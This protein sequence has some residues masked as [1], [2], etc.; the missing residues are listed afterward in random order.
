[1][2]TSTKKR[3]IVMVAMGGHAFMKEGQK[4]NNGENTGKET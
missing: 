2:D 4:G 3:P 1:M